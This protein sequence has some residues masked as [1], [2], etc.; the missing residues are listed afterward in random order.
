MAFRTASSYQQI[1]EIRRENGRNGVDEPGLE[2][3]LRRDR[4]QWY[5]RVPALM[6]VRRS[7]ISNGRLLG[8]VGMVLCLE[9][10]ETR[11]EKRDPSS[12]S[13]FVVA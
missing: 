12:R 9:G 5:H 6:M 8:C 7:W 11:V 13:D 4:K 1:P 2:F 10:V 3:D